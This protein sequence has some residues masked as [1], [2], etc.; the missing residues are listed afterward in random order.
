MFKTYVHVPTTTLKLTKPNHP[1][2]THSL[3]LTAL[4]ATNPGAATPDLW[5]RCLL[6]P[7]E[8]ERLL[9]VFLNLLFLLVREQ[10]QT[11]G[12]VVAI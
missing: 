6:L 10:A 4:H 7:A 12:C 3:H 8:V 1:P 11:G 2:H 9:Y 5:H